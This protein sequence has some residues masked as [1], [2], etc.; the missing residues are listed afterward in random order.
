MLCNG[1]NGDSFSSAKLP[2]FTVDASFSVI[3]IALWSSFVT[4]DELDSLSSEVLLSLSNFTCFGE[5]VT[6]KLLTRNIVFIPSLSQFFAISNPIMPLLCGN[7]LDDAPRSWTR[8]M[9]QHFIQFTVENFF[10]NWVSWFKQITASSAFFF[11][12]DLH[13]NNSWS[14]SDN[15]FTSFI[16]FSLI[17]FCTSSF[18]IAVFLL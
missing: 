15:S 18:V 8:K 13:H 2:R 9:L 3:R 10:N 12:P 17:S 6:A 14:Y 7:G 4:G 11:N 16:S 5:T 1:A